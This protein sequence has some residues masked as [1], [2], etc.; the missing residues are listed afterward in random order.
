MNSTP[1]SAGFGD[2]LQILVENQGRINYNIA[3][4]FKGIIGDVKVNNQVLYDWTITGFPFDNYEKLENLIKHIQN[5]PPKATESS[6]KAY[7]R[8]GPTI[9]HGQF[10]ITVDKIY[11]TYLDTT[12]WG[13]VFI[14]K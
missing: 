12:G 3:N 1:I 5:N 6:N 11:D 10:D 14:V 13:K 7:L 9:F 8:K 2:R 4:D